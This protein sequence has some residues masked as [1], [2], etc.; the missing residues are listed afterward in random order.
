[1]GLMFPLLSYF[2]T[3]GSLATDIGPASRWGTPTPQGTKE[4]NLS[5]IRSQR[6]M[7]RNTPC[8]DRLPSPHDI[9][10]L[11]QTHMWTLLY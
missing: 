1:M 9:S 8:W 2:E 5:E 6:L 7:R 10:T 4:W 3:G 11:L